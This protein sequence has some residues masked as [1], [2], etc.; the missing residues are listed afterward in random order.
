MKTNSRRR[1][2]EK[3]GVAG[4][5]GPALKK[6][7]LNQ[8]RNHVLGGGVL[9]VSGVSSKYARNLLEEPVLFYLDFF[10][11]SYLCVCVFEHGHA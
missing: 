10:C 7:E 1:E 9:W 8:Q 11:K 5:G 2:E 6:Q 3:V 4:A